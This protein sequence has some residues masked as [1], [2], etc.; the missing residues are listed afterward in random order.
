MLETKF[1]LLNFKPYND[2][3]FQSGLKHVVDIFIY[4]A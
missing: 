2:S 3:T 1:C 4:V